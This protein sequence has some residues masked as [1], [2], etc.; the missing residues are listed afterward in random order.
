M[1][2]ILFVGAVVVA[3]WALRAA[4]REERR[5]PGWQERAQDFERGRDV[6][7][8]FGKAAKVYERACDEGEVVACRHFALA[9]ASGRGIAVDRQE[10]G[11][12]FA[13]ACDA[14]D[15]PSCAWTLAAPNADVGRAAIADA[16]CEGGDTDACSALYAVTSWAVCDD[17][18]EDR[19]ARIARRGCARGDLYLCS[20]V[21]DRQEQE[22]EHV[23]HARGRLERACVDGD[24]DA[25]DW[26]R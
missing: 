11:A 16:A 10:A 6:P 9:L 22:L 8:D 24:I 1:Q 15:T 17:S 3:V 26:L 20:V 13:A 7:R 4:R 21:V 18:C 2:R 25:C 5:E 12:I 23:E 14:G 19:W